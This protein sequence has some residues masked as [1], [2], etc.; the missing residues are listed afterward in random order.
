MPMD[1]PYQIQVKREVMVA[2]CYENCVSRFRDHDADDGCYPEP[3]DT[4]LIEGS[5]WAIATRRRRVSRVFKVPSWIEQ[6]DG[7][8]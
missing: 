1:T 3:A 7:D 2:T 8:L 5:V 6:V 4:A